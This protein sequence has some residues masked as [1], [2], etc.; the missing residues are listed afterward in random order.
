MTGAKADVP[1]WRAVTAAGA[2]CLALA[3]A[4]ASGRA[5]AEGPDDASAPP[6]AILKTGA[7]YS[8]HA[9]NSSLPQL[10]TELGSEAGFTVVDSGK[11]H[12]PVTVT[13]DDVGLDVVLRRLLRDSNFII[14]YRG[15]KRGREISG[16][17]I[18]QITL[19]TPAGLSNPSA[20]PA[21]PAN[22]ASPLAGPQVAARGPH[23]GAQP[24][25]PG[26]AVPVNRPRAFNVLQQQQ[27]VQQPLPGQHLPPGQPGAPAMH[28]PG[29][30]V[31]V[32]QV[33]AV[34]AGPGGE[35]AAM[36]VDPAIGGV[37][38]VGQGVIEDSG[39][40]MPS[41]QDDADLDPEE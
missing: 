33:P 7:G 15:G 13:L 5:R 6:R 4:A 11:V 23:P 38:A 31:A 28:G 36:P 16:E 2:L 21:P 1:S 41:P 35:M 14:T 39:G 25:G 34:V 22:G 30:P 32:P 18:D 24:P 19:L 17:N 20:P 12:L 37:G 27:Q 29:A 26:G 8:V 40:S 10:L 9:N 3:I